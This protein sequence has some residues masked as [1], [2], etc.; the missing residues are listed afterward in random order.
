MGRN[1]LIVRARALGAALVW[2]FAPPFVAPASAGNLVVQEIRPS[3]ADPSITRFNE[4]NYVVIDDEATAAAQLVVFMPGTGGKPANASQL[5]GVVAHLGYRV[6]GLEYNDEP[7]VV[8]VCP[9]NPIASCSGNF[10]RRRIFGGD[11]NSDVANTESETIVTRLVN[12]SMCMTRQITGGIISK[13]ASRIGLA[14]SCPGC[15]RAPGWPHISRNESPS[16]EWS[17]SRARGIF[18]ATPID[19]RHG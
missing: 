7:A 9:K 1:S 18:N 13:P 19:W 12:I 10:R 15:R 17:Y 8:E 5:L 2:T 16:R 14:S 3:D 11:V 6:I 4:S